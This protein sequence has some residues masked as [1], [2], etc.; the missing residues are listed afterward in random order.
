MRIGADGVIT[1]PDFAGNRF[2]NTL[3]NFLVNPRGGLA[4]PDW[5]TGD[6]LQL[7]GDVE[8][9]FDS[10]EIKDFQGAERFWRFRPRQIL[11][12]P[13]ALPLRW[14]TSPEGQSPNSLMTGSWAEVE[15]R[16][17]AAP[18]ARRWR[19]FRVAKIV[20]ESAVIRSFHL[21]PTD[22]AGIIPQRPARF[23]QPV[24]CPR[25]PLRD[26]FGPIP[27]RLHPRTESVASAQSGRAWFPRS[28]MIACERAT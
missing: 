15:R 26:S 16:Q 4:F 2:F 19:P 14:A 10:P 25:R 18:L 11:Y 6:L 12:R 22:G 3:G 1:V 5:E 13:N 27:V 17:R 7:T 24:L 28:S 23:C 21:E 20:E 9:I 8:V